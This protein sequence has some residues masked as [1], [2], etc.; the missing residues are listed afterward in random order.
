[1]VK[2]DV[3]E[4]EDAGSIPDGDFLF[5]IISSILK[6]T[7]SNPVLS[8]V[9]LSYLVVYLRAAE[10]SHFFIIVYPIKSF[11]SP[12][13]SAYNHCILVQQNFHNVFIIVYPSNPLPKPYLS[14]LF[15][16]TLK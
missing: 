11:I 4:H 14:P 3:K 12:N 15:I 2:R 9:I 5:L 8:F 7:H 16:P 10:F 6:R 13:V 1:M